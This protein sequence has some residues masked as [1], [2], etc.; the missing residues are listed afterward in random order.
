LNPES[1][2]TNLIRS[3]FQNREFIDFAEGQDTSRK[4]DVIIPALHS[5]DLWREN[6]TSFYREIPINRLLI[7][8]AGCI[9]DTVA[10]A[11]EFPRVEIIDHRNITT[12]GAS[13]A[14]LIS[15]VTTSKF[16]YLQSDAYLPPGWCAAMESK[17]QQFAWVGSPMQVVTM[18]DYKVD[19]S[20]RRPL[21]GAQLGD[22]SAFKNL[23]EFI[24]D[25]FVYRQEDFVLEEFV[26]RRGYAT[27]NSFET[28]HFH[29]VMRRNT[30]GMQMNVENISIKLNEAPKEKDRVSRTQ[31]YGLL[32][33]CDP[34]IREV[35]LAAFGAY[36]EQKEDSFTKFHKAIKF[37]VA[38]N[39]NWLS[40]IFRFA[41]KVLVQQGISI[42]SSI[43]IKITDTIL[44]IR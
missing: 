9:D 38:H 12:L 6:L 36:Q 18:L 2:S 3:L 24:D 30:T 41:I 16:A 19:Y 5:N 15:R 7:G 32:K 43:L 44:R 10:V 42:T 20:G 31:L 14:E 17:S 37:S 28:F 40:L 8:D 13:I 1:G 4:I 23:G 26:R 22:T 39:K 33:Y 25:D 35:R 34:S 29:Q 27:G 21:A 11:K